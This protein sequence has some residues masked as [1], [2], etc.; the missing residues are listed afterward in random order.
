MSYIP[1]VIV[2]AGPSG[3]A[4][5]CELKRH[6]IA[7]RLIDKKPQPTLTSNAAA[8][9]PRTLEIFHQL[10]IADRFLARG[11]PCHGVNVHLGNFNRTILFDA[12][13]SPY[14]YILMLPQSET[15]AILTEKLNE[16]AVNIERNTELTALQAVEGRYELTLGCEGKHELLVCDWVIACDGAH[17]A[18][19]KFTSTTFLGD[20]YPDNFMVADVALMQ[21][22]STDKVNIYDSK[23]VILGLFPLGKHYRLVANGIDEKI[24]LTESFVKEII[25]KRTRGQCEMREMV[26]ASH[27]WIHSRMADRLRKDRIFFLGD[28]AHI[29]SPVGGQGM[30]TGIQDAHNL[31]WK[32]A[33][34]MR[35][36]ASSL[37]LDSYEAERL[38][39]IRE[40]VKSTERMTRLMASRWRIISWVRRLFFIY[41]SRSKRMREKLSNMVGQLSIRYTQS[42]IINM[43]NV[44]KDAPVLPGEGAPDVVISGTMRLFDYFKH[45]RHTILIFTGI[46]AEPRA[47]EEAKVLYHW[48][49][50]CF[51]YIAQPYIVAA[52]P[53]DLDVGVILDTEGA[54]HRAYRATSTR[55]C[56][57]R[58]DGVVG[59]F[60]TL[61]DE[62]VAQLYFDALLKEKA[63]VS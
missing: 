25:K 24:Q 58:P 44:P 59:L 14:P 61:L 3:L 46:H 49:R 33:L 30:N 19:R 62:E 8:V 13:H 41:L 47:N 16:Y 17:S 10:G 9:Q 38:P 60:Q 42:P 43:N 63:L 51:D 39:V 5:A 52:N 11:I 1:V 22:I 28:A 34:V 35:G 37:L 31:A 26:W 48:L 53:I 57:I 4:M 21:D 54:L 20:D 18:V 29:H 55:L 15:E 36:E 50:E 2:G 12:I 23:G 7:Y 40:I 45:A 27:F 6:G 56:I 32:L